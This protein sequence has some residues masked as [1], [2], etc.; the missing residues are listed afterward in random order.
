MIINHGEEEE[1]C[2]GSEKGSAGDE[3]EIAE[4]EI[5]AATLVLL[6]LLVVVGFI[7][8]DIAAV[9]VVVPSSIPGLAL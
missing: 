1:K 6:L 9:A 7:G 3:D 4:V 5:L 2:E 8:I